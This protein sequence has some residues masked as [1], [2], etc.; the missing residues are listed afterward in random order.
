MR[1]HQLALAVI[2]DG[3]HNGVDGLV[4]GDAAGIALDLAQRIGVLASLGVLDGAERNVAVGVILDGLD[5]LRV[6]ALYLA[7]LEAKLA[8]LEVASVQ[9][10][11]DLNLVGDTGLNGICS[12]GV[13]ELSLARGHLHGSAEL[14]LCVG[15][16]RHGDLRDILAI[17]DAVDDLASVL[18]ADLINVRAGLGIV[19]LAEANGR[20]ALGHSRGRKLGNRG[21]VLGRRREL[22]LKLVRIRPLAA[23]EHLG[24]TKVSLGI[25][26]CRRHIVLIANLAVVAQMNVNLRGVRLGRRVIPLGIEHIGRGAGE[27]AA[28]ALLGGMKLVNK[29]QARGS[30]TKRQVAARIGHDCAPKLRGMSTVKLN[31]SCTGLGLAVCA[32]HLELIL[33]VID[34]LGSQRTRRGRCAAFIH[35][36]GSLLLEIVIAVGIGG[37]KVRN[38]IAQRT[39]IPLVR[40]EVYGLGAVPRGGRIAL[41]VILKPYYLLGCKQV[42]ERVF[43]DARGIAHLYRLSFVDRKHAIFD[44]KVT[45]RNQRRRNLNRYDIA[46]LGLALF[47]TLNGDDQVRGRTSKCIGVDITLG[48]LC[49]VGKRLAVIHDRRK[50][51]DLHKVAQL[52][53]KRNVAGLML[54]ITAVN[55]GR[56]TSL[57]NASRDLFEDFL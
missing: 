49:M 26:R 25:H 44:L 53:G 34:A 15:R 48:T 17:G 11:G 29:G 33:V 27:V 10:L 40:V 2:A 56:V 21:I 57:D 18:L 45:Q 46:G 41:N 5:K 22:K 6:L 36:N 20:I 50:V 32:F 12:V 55:F 14:A 9:D 13:Y 19:N 1:S 43:L 24:Q 35:I 16:N 7:Q 30:L 4:V 37:L 38:R 3:R 54:A 47:G 42:I 52:I 8:V 28:H 51:V 31:N 39:A 23:L